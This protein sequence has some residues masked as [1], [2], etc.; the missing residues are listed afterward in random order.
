MKWAIPTLWPG[1]TVAI[2]ASGPSMSQA[3]ANRIRERAVPCIAVNT[4]FVLAPWASMIYA[5]DDSWWQYHKKKVDALA[6]PETLKVTVEPSSFMDLLWLTNG[7]RLGLLDEGP[8]HIATGANSGFQAVQVAI[9]AGAA[10]IELHGFDMQSKGGYH[11]WHG[12]HPT[13]HLRNHGEDQYISWISNFNS[14]VEPV[15]KLGVRIVNCTPGSALT[16]FE[17]QAAP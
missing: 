8:T 2:L 5:A 16:C 7:G 1:A 11:H 14:I 4:T 13:S 6:S 15:K 9:K 10:N 12:M 17:S 3:V